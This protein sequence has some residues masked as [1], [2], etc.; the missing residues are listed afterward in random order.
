MAR[1]YEC[2]DDSLLEW[3]SLGSR[4]P[5][6]GDERYRP[7]DLLD[8]NLEHWRRRYQVAANKPLRDPR[9][10]A[11]DWAQYEAARGAAILL[12][13]HNLP[14]KLGR[15]SQF[16]RLTGLLCGREGTDLRKICGR[17]RDEIR[18]RELG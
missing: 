5:A 13:K 1:R 11:V 17:V 4:D 15:A 16:V 2:Y 7:D 3:L 8:E 9:Y 6:R 18:R 12:R 10:N 14:L